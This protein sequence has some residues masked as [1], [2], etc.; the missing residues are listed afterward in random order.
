MVEVG[1]DKV[2]ARF[3]LA[4]NLVP[5]RELS[6]HAV[7]KS[8]NIGGVEWADMNL[9]VRTF[10]DG[11]RIPVVPSNAYSSWHQYTNPY[12]PLP[13][14]CHYDYDKANCVKYGMFYYLLKNGDL[15]RV[16]P[17]GWEIP[18]VAQ[19][20]AMMRATYL[21]KYGE[22]KDFADGKN[23]DGDVASKLWVALRDGAFGAVAGSMMSYE[24]EPDRAL[25]VANVDDVTNVGYAADDH[26]GVGFVGIRQDGTGV[27]I[28]GLSDTGGY[29][30]PCSIR[31]VRKT[32]RT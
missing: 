15:A 29:N 2:L 27:L 8:V 13:A 16:C 26:R 22:E 28:T 19:W 10:N 21:A 25:W 24:P 7:L 1:S 18:T 20:H 14:M 5:L 6:C 17:V 23:W 4:I 30:W 9:D 12:P 11:M 3:R 32:V 31:L